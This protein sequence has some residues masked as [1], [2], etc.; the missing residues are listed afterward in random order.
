MATTARGT[1]TLL[2]ELEASDLA[3]WFA[4]LPQEDEALVDGSAGRPVRWIEGR[5]W[6]EEAE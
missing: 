3:E 5:G 4:S 6:L 1:V 2:A